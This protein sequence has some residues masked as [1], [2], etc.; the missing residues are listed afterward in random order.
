MLTPESNA[1]RAMFFAMTANK[2]NP[3]E[4]GREIKT[5]GMIGAGFMGGP[6]EKQLEVDRRLI[7]KR[8]VKLKKEMDKVKKNTR[9]CTKEQGTYSLSGYSTC[10]LYQCRKINFIQ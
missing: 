6:G 7:T 3:F 2:K 5:L 4:G 8:I 9:T 1:L 10:W